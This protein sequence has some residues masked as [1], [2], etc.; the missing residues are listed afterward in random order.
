M[1]PKNLLYE[2]ENKWWLERSAVEKYSGT[3]VSN[4]HHLAIDPYKKAASPS[5]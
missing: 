5:G 2:E 1:A 4:V 3:V